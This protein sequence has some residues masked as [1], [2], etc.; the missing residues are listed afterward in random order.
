MAKIKEEKILVQ[1]Y[2]EAQKIKFIEELKKLTMA[3][4][5]AEVIRNCLFLYGDIVKMILDGYEI[6]AVNLKTGKV[7]KIP[8]GL[9]S[10]VKIDIN[11]DRT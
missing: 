5:R 4:T 3:S 1:L 2:F 7:K 11:A 10:V 6:Q 9:V 8:I